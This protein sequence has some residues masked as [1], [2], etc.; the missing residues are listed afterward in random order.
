VRG[1]K[2]KYYGA[3]GYIT[4][5]ETRPGV[6]EETIVERMYSGDVS[7]IRRR[8]DGQKVNDDVNISNQI[9]IVADP[10][11]FENFTAIRYIVWLNQKLKVTNITVEPPRMIFEVG[12]LYNE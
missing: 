2:M 6:W 7:S 5:V 1:L 11:A 9:S 3:V 12:G 8:L 10:Y 4:T